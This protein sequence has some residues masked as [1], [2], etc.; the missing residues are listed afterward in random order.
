MTKYFIHIIF[1]VLFL[2]SCKQDKKTYD[3]D[4]IEIVEYY[5]DYTKQI[6]GDHILRGAF[7]AAIENNGDCKVVVNSGGISQFRIFQIPDSVL[8]EL[9]DNLSKI[10]DDTTIHPAFDKPIIYDGPEVSFIY[11]SRNIKKRVTFLDDYEFSEPNCHKF[12]KFIKLYQTSNNRT[13]TDT[14][15]MKNLRMKRLESIYDDWYQ[16]IKSNFDSTII[17]PKNR[18]II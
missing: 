5:W 6:H 15:E 10:P 7:Y 14:N 16:F 1:L 17:R 11:S 8:I 3:F 2:A 4:R 9:L 18:K 12:Y 13:F